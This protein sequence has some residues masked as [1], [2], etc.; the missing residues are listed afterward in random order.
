MA[1]Y[2]AARYRNSMAPFCVLLQAMAELRG[3]GILT[4]TLFAYYVFIICLFL[5][6]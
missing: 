1:T 2:V 6:S 5:L 4:A 3:D